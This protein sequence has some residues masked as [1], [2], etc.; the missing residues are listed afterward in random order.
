MDQQADFLVT[1]FIFDQQQ[2]IDLARESLPLVRGIMAAV[3]M[4]DEPKFQEA[5]HRIVLPHK[6]YEVFREEVVKVRAADP[7]GI[8][9][10]RA[11]DVLQKFL[12][13]QSHLHMLSLAHLE[14]TNPSNPLIIKKVMLDEVTKAIDEIK[15]IRDAIDEMLKVP[16]TYGP[17]TLRTKSTPKPKPKEEEKMPEGL[18]DFIKMISG[19]TS[20]AAVRLGHLPGCNCDTHTQN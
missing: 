2:M 15:K 13:V 8:T 12:S 19:S 18:M 7:T 17:I 10:Q 6:S 14:S 20:V 16:I 9:G 11:V 1:K 5:I 3:W 4:S